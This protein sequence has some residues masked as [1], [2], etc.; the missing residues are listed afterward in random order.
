MATRMEH[1]IPVE[2]AKVRHD[3]ERWRQQQP[4]Q[5]AMI[6]ESFWAEAVQL[7]G[8]YGVSRTARAL[9]LH[10]G[11]LKRLVAAGTPVAPAEAP[12]E[13]LEWIAPA[14]V[15]GADCVL[16]LEARQGGKLRLEIK[17][18]PPAELATLVRALIPE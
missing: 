18:V 6:P 1:K 12:P 9:R 5:R 15:R 14:A 4:C 17:G 2:L 8:K 11:R 13:F 3:L 10:Y 7:A 16:E